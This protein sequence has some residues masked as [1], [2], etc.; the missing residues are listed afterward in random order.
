MIEDLQPVWAARTVVTIAAR[1]RAQ[2]RR[3]MGDRGGS[4][5]IMFTLAMV[6]MILAAGGGADVYVNWRLQ[7]S[8]QNVAD[9]AVLAGSLALDGGGNAGTT[10]STYVTKNFDEPNQTSTA[11]TTKVDA[12]TGTVSVDLVSSSGTTFLKMIGLKSIPLHVRSAATYGGG[13]LEVALAIDVTGSMDG[14]K[15]TAARKAAKDLVSTLFTVPGTNKV[16]DKVRMGLVPFTRYVRIST[17]LRG[18]TWLDAPADSSTTVNE[19]WTED[20]GGYCTATKTVNT[21]CTNDGVSSPCSWE[22]CTNW[23][24]GKIVQVCGPRTYS[25]VWYGCVGSRNYPLDLQAEVSSAAKVPSIWDDYCPLELQRLTKDQTALNNLIDALVPYEETYIAPGMLWAWRLVSSKAPFA[26]GSADAKT[27]HKAIILMTDGAN[28][29][30]AS[31]P[32]HSSNDVADANS[33][34]LKTCTNA[35]ADN[36]SIFT[37]AFAVTD[38]AIKQTLTNCATS[39]SYFFDA[40]SS[41]EMLA[42]FRQIGAQLSSR[43][44]VY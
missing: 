12:A 22:E 43:R 14:A 10:V 18:Q 40:G 19:C 2:A 23:V 26:D 37:I 29:F 42:A 31:Y 3:L 16:N 28:T 7:T 13:L 25:K 35:K 17:A 24:P 21:T 15:M 30:S 27:N 36:V 4:T 11:V 20:Q 41:T 6:P 44:L 9:S 1:L 33:V 34:L 38:S 32:A 39:A 8:L 5:A